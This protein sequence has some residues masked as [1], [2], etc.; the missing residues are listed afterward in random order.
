MNS[1]SVTG[2]GGGLDAG[3]QQMVASAGASD[4]EQ[5]AFG[6]VDLLQVGL[7]GDVLDALLQW[8]HVVVAGHHCDD[9][10]FQ[11]FCTR[12]TF[13]GQHNFQDI[14]PTTYD[15]LL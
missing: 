10:K 12:L 15:T 11:A 5:V 8:D 1:A 2:D 13:R 9:A 4:V 3:D 14:R 7:V 6:V